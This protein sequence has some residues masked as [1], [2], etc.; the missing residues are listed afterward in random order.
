MGR[1]GVEYMVVGDSVQQFTYRKLNIRSKVKEKLL[2]QRM[3]EREWCLD[4]VKII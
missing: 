4:E 3:K 2:R 1:G